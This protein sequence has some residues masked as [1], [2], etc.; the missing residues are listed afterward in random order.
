MKR[1]L[2]DGQPGV[3]EIVQSCDPFDFFE[4]IVPGE[5][6]DNNVTYSNLDANKGFKKHLDYVSWRTILLLKSD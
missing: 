2:F 1:H 6:V 3:N 5:I 4:L